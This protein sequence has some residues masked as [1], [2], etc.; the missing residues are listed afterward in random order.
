MNLISLPLLLADLEMRSCHVEMEQLTAISPHPE[1][2]DC[3]SR[4]VAGSEVD[5]SEHLVHT[6]CPAITVRDIR[7]QSY[8][9]IF[10]KHVRSAYVHEDQISEYADAVPMASPGRGVSYTN[11]IRAPFRRIHFEASW[12]VQ[13]IRILAINIEPA[14]AKAPL[15]RPRSWWIDGG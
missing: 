12:L 9:N 13:L 15:P 10:Y 8:G 11:V 6:S 4:V 5:T 2:L 3:L 7:A 14:L 1:G